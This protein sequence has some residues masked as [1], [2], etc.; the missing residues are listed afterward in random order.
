[1][2]MH[3]DRAHLD[4]LLERIPDTIDFGSDEEHGCR[5]LGEWLERTLRKELGL[6]CVARDDDGVIPVP[7]GDNVVY[8]TEGDADAEFLTVSALLAE[9]FVPSFE[10]YEAVNAINSDT[11]MAKT[12]VTGD[13]IVT[14][15]HLPVIDTLSAADLVLALD[16]VGGVVERFAG[17]LQSRFRTV[18]A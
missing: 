17:R 6:V 9:G 12:V 18:D 7:L 2:V 14:T 8:V 16:I 4:E 5:D 10:V 11:P 1:M 3:I 13:Q 15:V